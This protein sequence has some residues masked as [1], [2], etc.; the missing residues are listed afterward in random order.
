MSTTENA[1][2]EQKQQKASKTAQT[3]KTTTKGYQ[4]KAGKDTFDFS[5]KADAIKKVD[6]LKAEKVNIIKLIDTKGE[7]K[8]YVYTRRINSKSYIVKS[9]D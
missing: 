4:V 5:K 3:E 9:E 2:K 7:E 1:Q 6:A 8:T